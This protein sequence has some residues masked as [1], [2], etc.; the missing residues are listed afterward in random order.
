MEIESGKIY[1][2]SGGNGIG[3]TSLLKILSQVNESIKYNSSS[4]KFE[5]NTSKGYVHQDYS[6]SIL[7]WF[8]VYRNIGLPLEILGTDSDQAIVKAKQLCNDFGFAPE[9]ENPNELSGGEKQI[10]ILLRAIIDKPKLLLLDEPFS[11]INNL[12]LGTVFRM[13]YL[14]FLKKMLSPL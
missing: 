10:L 12:E 11:A 5:E 1:G 2:I 4:I 9:S 6:K 13:K 8:N 7:Q 14:K 3:K